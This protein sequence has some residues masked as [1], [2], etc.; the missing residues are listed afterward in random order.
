MSSHPDQS[1]QYSDADSSQ[2]P[3]VPRRTAMACQFCRGRKLK[4]DGNRPSCT[5][6]DKRGFACNYVP[7]I[8]SLCTMLVLG[9]VS[10][11]V[12]MVEVELFELRIVV[13]L[14]SSPPH[15]PRDTHA[16]VMASDRLKDRA[17]TLLKPTEKARS[18]QSEPCISESIG[19][20]FCTFLGAQQSP[21]VVESV[22][23]T[24]NLEY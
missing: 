7:V 19:S 6:C 17:R 14:F 13:V 10:Q 20:A 8:N 24:Y 23:Y 15:R 12:L 3:R 18:K 22:P 4:C 1:Y 21:A 2:A 11:L 16:I 9:S 5:N